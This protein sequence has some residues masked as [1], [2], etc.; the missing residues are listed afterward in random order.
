MIPGTSSSLIYL[1]QRQPDVFFAMTI[2]LRFCGVA[3]PSY[4]RRD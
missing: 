2:A 3:T 4:A 1:A